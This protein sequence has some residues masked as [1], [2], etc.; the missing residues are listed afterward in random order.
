[1]ANPAFWTHTNYLNM[2]LKTKKKRN[3]SCRAAASHTDVTSECAEGFSA[4]VHEKEKQQRAASFFFF[5]WDVGK[6]QRFHSNPQIS[7]YFFRII[8]IL[9][10]V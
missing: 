4:V 9:L 5:W 8:V 3:H 6:D 7:A 10:Y 2:E 1:M